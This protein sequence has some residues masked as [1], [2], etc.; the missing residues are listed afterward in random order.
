VPFQ[1]QVSVAGSDDMTLENIYREYLPPRLQRALRRSRL[2]K[3]GARPLYSLDKALRDSLPTTGIY[4]EIGANDGLTQS[5]TWWLER[6][7]GWRGILIEPA[8]NKYLELVKNRSSLNFFACAACVSRDFEGE[9]VEMMY[10]DLMTTSESVELMGVANEEHH[11][12]A[13]GHA[14]DQVKFFSPAKTISSIIDA[15]GLGSQIDFFSLDVEGAELEVLG[16]IDFDRHRVA[17]ILVETR[18]VEAVTSML[19]KLGYGEPQQLT[20]HDYL[21]SLDASSH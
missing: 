2:P 18:R 7:G 15:A 21:Y 9:Y 4:L 8:L 6:S 12:D 19:S 13:M 5:N 20:V 3:V 10:A 14:P 11:H 1:H 17:K 16:G